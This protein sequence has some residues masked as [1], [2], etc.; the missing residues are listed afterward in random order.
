MKRTVQKAF[1]LAVGVVVML[2]TGC[3]EPEPPRVKK[4][5]LI[6][7]ENMQLTKELAQRSKEIEELNELHDRQLEEQ[8]ELLAKSL[9]ERE[10][11]KKK[12]QQ[13][14]RG[15][16]EGVLEAVMEQNAQ[17]RQE[18]EKLKAQI[19]KLKTK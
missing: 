9:E 16:V 12:S 6:A 18:N 8:K 11:W 17:L 4:R 2:M 15:Q 1:V 19:E 7:A 10:S 13:N 5:S 14:V 3:G